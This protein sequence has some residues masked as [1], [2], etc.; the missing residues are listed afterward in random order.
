MVVV[1]IDMVPD[2]SGVV[3]NMSG[4]GLIIIARTLTTET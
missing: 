1:V 4:V 3:G 2:D